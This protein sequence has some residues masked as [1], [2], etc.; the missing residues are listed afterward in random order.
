[1]RDS[2]ERTTSETGAEHDSAADSKFR[3]DLISP[4]AEERLAAW[5][6]RGA[7]KYSD[8]NWEKG[9]PA[10][11]NLASLRRHVVQYMQGDR[12]EDH[13][14]AVMC[15]AMFLLHF[16]ELERRGT[17]AASGL[18]DLPA[19]GDARGPG[20]AFPEKTSGLSLTETA[21]NVMTSSTSP[22]AELSQAATCRELT[23]R[24]IASGLSVAADA[25]TRCCARDNI[26]ETCT[27][28]YAI[29][30]TRRRLQEESEGGHE[31]VH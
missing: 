10:S 6:A 31:N 18:C 20:P 26:S 27:I 29:S 7:K 30:V 13:L 21:L 8:R 24:L 2:G 28:A 17:P 23:S 1:M 9:I 16:D 5:L 12:E 3:P 11:V 19:Y 15:R 14:A 22:N 25:V 4:F